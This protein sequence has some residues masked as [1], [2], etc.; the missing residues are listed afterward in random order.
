MKS[1]N[2]VSSLNLGPKEINTPPSSR[3]IM[4]IDV[5]SVDSTGENEYTDLKFE[6]SSNN[7]PKSSL[8][9]RGKIV[10]GSK[11]ISSFL[12]SADDYISD[13]VGDPRTYSS[14]ESM[15]SDNDLM[16]S[17]RGSI[18]SFVQDPAQKRQQIRQLEKSANTC[19]TCAPGC[20]IF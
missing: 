3:R 15:Y 14:V 5:Q 6:N 7:G 17:G 11:N 16:R 8:S 13:E 9:A 1:K 10:A 18:Q 19:E 12:G 4:G 20:N 2:S